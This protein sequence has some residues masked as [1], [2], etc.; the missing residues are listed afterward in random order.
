MTEKPFSRPI[1][2]LLTLANREGVDIRPTL[3]RVLTDLY[4]QT[5]S[6]TPSEQAQYTELATRLIDSVDEAARASTYARLS[7]YNGAPDAVLNHLRDLGAPHPPKAAAQDERAIDLF[8][9]ADEFERRFM[10]ANLDLGLSKT[11]F[12]AAAPAQETCRRLEIAALEHNRDEF[13]RL[14]AR[15]LGLS[16]DTARRIANDVTGDALVVV[17]R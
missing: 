6:H 1:D 2:G 8:L 17:A 11:S 9:K 15:A 5:P 14:I 12:S 13:P 3:L 4:V 16:P 7:T 10:I